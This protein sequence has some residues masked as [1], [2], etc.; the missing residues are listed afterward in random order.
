MQNYLIYSAFGWLIL[1]GTLHFAIDVV[2]QYVR[3]KRAPSVETTLYYG[4]NSAFSL[5]QVAF[6]LLGLCIAWR[7]MY[8]FN[9]TPVLI[10]SAFVGV[11]WLAITF[12][13]MEYLEPKFAVG[14]FCLLIVAA[15]VAN[16]YF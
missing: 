1:S 2:S 9:E 7:A 13:F 15:L 10:L 4:L 14:I 16:L 12:L 3:G 5:G 8:L 11:G 6:G